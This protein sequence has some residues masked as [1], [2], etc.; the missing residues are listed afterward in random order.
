MVICT[1]RLSAQ[2]RPFHL[3]YYFGRC[4]GSQWF[5]GTDIG[6]PLSILIAPCHSNRIVVANLFTDQLRQ[7]EKAIPPT[8]IYFSPTRPTHHTPRIPP[9]LGGGGTKPRSP[10]GNLIQQLRGGLCRC[11]PGAGVNPEDLPPRRRH[12]ELE[13]QLSIEAPGAPQG[14]IQCVG[15]VCRANHHHL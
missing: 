2:C 1:S 10:D 7:T 14:G 8:Q 15:P 12:G 3:S 6:A 13:P 5:P 4:M 11:S 9:H